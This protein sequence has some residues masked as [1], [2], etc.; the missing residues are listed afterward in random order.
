MVKESIIEIG[1]P[2]RGEKSVKIQGP[3]FVEGW[4]HKLVLCPKRKRK[5]VFAESS[6][7]ESDEDEES[8]E[9]DSSDDESLS[10]LLG[11]KKSGKSADLSMS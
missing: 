7:E 11:D 4:E 3:I 2:E 5:V 9:E 8:E 6:S 1:E 10:E